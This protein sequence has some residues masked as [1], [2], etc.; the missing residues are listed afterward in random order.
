MKHTGILRAALL[1]S[2][3]GLTTALSGC[4]IAPPH[5]RYRE[6]YY[7]R[8]HGRYYHGHDWVACR[9]NDVHCR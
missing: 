4:I 5:E 9:H 8:A 1:V 3:Y 7:D 2:L 6:G